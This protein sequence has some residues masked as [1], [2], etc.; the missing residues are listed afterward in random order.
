MGNRALVIFHDKYRISPTVYLHWH[1]GEVPAILREL[2]EYMTGPHGDAE[3]AAARFAGLCH[4]RINGNLSLGIMSNGAPPR[5]PGR[6]GLAQGD[7]ARRCRPGDRRF[8]RFHVESLRRLSGRRPARPAAPA[9][10]LVKPSKPEL[11]K[12][13]NP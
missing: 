5:R 11:P 8:R 6:C 1:G 2:T 3:Y 9:L 10:T 13:T 7:V 12:G 4:T